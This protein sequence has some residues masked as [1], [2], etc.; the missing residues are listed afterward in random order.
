MSLTNKIYDLLTDIRLIR[1]IRLT[2][3]NTVRSVKYDLLRERVKQHLIQIYL[4]YTP[5]N[6]TLYTIKYSFTIQLDTTQLY[7]IQL[8]TIQ[9]VYLGTELN[10]NL[11][12][13]SFTKDVC[14]L[15][16][17]SPKIMSQV[18]GC[19]SASSI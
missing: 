8:Y 6:Y 19:D 4:Y 10:S 1:S 12:T 16:A 9:Y 17:E 5:Y 14:R 15:V 11:I 18:C 7:T 3:R 13:Y 2:E